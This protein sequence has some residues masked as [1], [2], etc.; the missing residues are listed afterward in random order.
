MI[1]VFN[2]SQRQWAFQSF[3][4]FVPKHVSLSDQVDRARRL[5]RGKTKNLLS[6]M[7][8]RPK[9]A[10]AWIRSSV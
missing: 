4:N 3:G 6:W 5:K 10:I 8:M 1:G 2:P 9:N 7:Q